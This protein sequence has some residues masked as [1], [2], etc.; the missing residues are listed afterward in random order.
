MV[1]YKNREPFILENNVDFKSFSLKFSYST[2]IQKSW[3]SSNSTAIKKCI[4]QE[5]LVGLGFSKVLVLLIET[6]ES[7]IFPGNQLAR[8][9]TFWYRYCEYPF[10]FSQKIE[11][12]DYILPL[13]LI[14]FI[15]SGL[16]GFTMVFVLTM[17]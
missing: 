1:C 7:L 11:V 4:T 10:L 2:T 8:V 16:S 12:A 17:A 13:F 5:I 15:V 9:L 14:Y 3:I 6:T